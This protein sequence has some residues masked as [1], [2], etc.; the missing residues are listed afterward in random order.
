M[1]ENLDKAIA[2]PLHNSL[3][4]LKAKVELLENVPHTVRVVANDAVPSKLPCT[5]ALESK[6]FALDL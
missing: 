1:I 5:S 6:G 3:A 4:V 2:I